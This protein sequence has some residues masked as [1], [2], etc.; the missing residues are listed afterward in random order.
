MAYL[1]IEISDD[2]LRFKDFKYKYCIGLKYDNKFNN[3]NITF[4]VANLYKY[5]GYSYSYEMFEQDS[6]HH[7]KIKNKTIGY[8]DISMQQYYCGS[9]DIVSYLHEIFPD[10]FLKF[11]K[12]YNIYIRYK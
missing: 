3:Y 5:H 6:R 9:Y 4:I 7:N 12:S 10:D 2:Y 1:D 8:E 11:L